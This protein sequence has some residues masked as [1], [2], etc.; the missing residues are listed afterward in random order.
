MHHSAHGCSLSTRGVG[1]VID[2]QHAQGVVFLCQCFGTQGKLQLP[3]NYIHN[4]Q[5]CLILYYQHT[6][7]TFIPFTLTA[8]QNSYATFK[9]NFIKFTFEPSYGALPERISLNKAHAMKWPFTGYLQNHT[10]L[11]SEYMGLCFFRRMFILEFTPAAHGRD[12]Y[13]LLVDTSCIVM[14]LA[15]SLFVIRSNFALRDKNSKQEGLR[16]LDLLYLQASTYQSPWTMG[17]LG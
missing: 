17:L 5:N 11:N 1:W 15:R 13:I 2:D 12:A 14:H 3:N 10:L 16:K 7:W 8:I 6:L 4:T 9:L